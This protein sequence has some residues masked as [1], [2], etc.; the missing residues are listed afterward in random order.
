MHQPELE[1]AAVSTFGT[2]RNRSEH[3]SKTGRGPKKALAE[4]LL[5]YSVPREDQ[6]GPKGDPGPGLALPEP[7]FEPRA[8]PDVLRGGPHN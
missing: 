6:A 5:G 4:V 8:A 7:E 2:A 1:L 3:Q